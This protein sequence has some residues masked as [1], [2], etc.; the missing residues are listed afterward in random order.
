VRP[1]LGWGGEGLGGGI[2]GG[3]GKRK[4]AVKKSRKTSRKGGNLREFVQK[5]EKARENNE[6]D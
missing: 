3:R 4:A 5:I 1:G 2:A 6:S